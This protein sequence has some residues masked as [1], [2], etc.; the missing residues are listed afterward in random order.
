MLLVTVIRSLRAVITDRWQKWITNLFQILPYKYPILSKIH[1][2]SSCY[3]SKPSPI[4]VPWQS[5]TACT[6]L[7]IVTSAISLPRLPAGTLG[8]SMS[9]I[10]NKRAGGRQPFSLTCV[11][12]PS[13]VAL[14]V[15]AQLADSLPLCMQAARRF[16]WL[17]GVKRATGGGD[18]TDRLLVSLTLSV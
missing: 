9:G 11:S 17:C 18:T 10:G 2:N 4:A 5:L 15:C 6:H 8:I 14:T 16:L 7:L 3:I 1:Q 12:R 13:L